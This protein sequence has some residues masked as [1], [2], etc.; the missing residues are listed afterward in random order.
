MRYITQ[1]LSAWET[2]KLDHRA[3]LSQMAVKLERQ[4]GRALAPGCEPTEGG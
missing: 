3:F 1:A 2:N 4:L